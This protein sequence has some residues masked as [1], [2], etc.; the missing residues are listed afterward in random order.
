V[1]LTRRNRYFGFSIVSVKDITTRAISGLLTSFSPVSSP[2][3]ASRLRRYL[4]FIQ[5][6]GCL[7]SSYHLVR[8]FV[9]PGMVCEVQGFLKNFGDLS[10]G[11]FSFV[12]AVHTFLL[13]AGGRKWQPYAIKTKSGIL[14]WYICM[15]IW[16]II[17]LI[18]TAGFVIQNAQPEKGPFC[19]STSVY[20]TNCRY[21]YRDRMVLDRRTI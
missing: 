7:L 12:V 21:G 10:S 8:G 17:F 6:I 3:F 20:L 13:L 5:S 14:R 1:P 18:A 9:A 11:V 2:Q 4:D 19:L 16:A 15:A